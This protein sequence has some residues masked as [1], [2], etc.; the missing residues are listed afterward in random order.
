MNNKTYDDY[1]RWQQA[2]Q[3]HSVHVNNKVHRA[4]ED[5]CAHHNCDEDKADLLANFFDNYDEE[6][7]KLIASFLS[8][9]EFEEYAESE[10]YN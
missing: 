1:K 9:D 7:V 4:Y 3:P 6:D 8:S 10:D 2:H 5:W